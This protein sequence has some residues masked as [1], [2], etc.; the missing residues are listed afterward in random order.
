LTELNALLKLLAAIILSL[1]VIGQVASATL[2]KSV[3]TA[4]KQANIPLSSVGIVVQQTDART[5]LL[6]ENAKL[7]MNPASTMKLLT[8]FAS[9]EMLGPAYSWKTEAYLDGKLENGVLQGNL[10]FKGYGNPKLTIE[11]FWLWLRELR[12][13]GLREIQGD[14]VLDRSFFEATSHDPAEFCKRGSDT[15]QRAAQP[16]FIWLPDQQSNHGCIQKT[17]QWRRYL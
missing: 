10:I 15:T 13:R 4:L 2:P 14:I 6:G 5:S 16:G 3:R 11:Q 7:A 1:G 9:L 12:Q 8:T 17:M